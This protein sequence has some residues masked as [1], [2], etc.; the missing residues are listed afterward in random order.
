[1]NNDFLTIIPSGKYKGM[2]LYNE[3]MCGGEHVLPIEMYYLFQNAFKNNYKVFFLKCKPNHSINIANN[4]LDFL[5]TPFKLDTEEDEKEYLKHKFSENILKI[6]NLQ[7]E[8]LIQIYKNLIKDRSVGAFFLYPETINDFYCFNLFL[9]IKIN[10]VVEYNKNTLTV[11]LMKNIYDLSKLQYKDYIIPFDDMNKT[12]PYNLFDLQE[13][14]D[15]VNYYDFYFELKKK[16][17]NLDT[18]VF[19]NNISE[20]ENKLSLKESEL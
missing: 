4:D 8:D 19:Q 13:K 18:T 3:H 10:S 2:R 7:Y 14:K 1:L 12:R 9:I 6:K 16:N 11:E 5:K 15:L 17:P 20:L